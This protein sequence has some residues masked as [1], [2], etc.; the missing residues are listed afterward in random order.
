MLSPRST[1][2][3]TVP[4][5][6]LRVAWTPGPGV[7][8]VWARTT[9]ST[10]V[11]TPSSQCLSTAV[12]SGATG[13]RRSPCMCTSLCSGG[14]STP[15]SGRRSCISA[16]GSGGGAPWTRR[17]TLKVAPFIQGCQLLHGRCLTADRLG[18]LAGFAW[19]AGG[20]GGLGPGGLGGLR[21]GGLWRTV[22][23]RWWTHR[24]HCFGITPFVK[25]CRTSMC[26]GW[27]FHGTQSVLTIWVDRTF[28]YLSI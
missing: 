24:I 20:L 16:W 12:Q 15:A 22:G 10:P 27:K 26:T 19:R 2:T 9:A 28:A 18:G 17:C 3:T 23:R 14:S 5:P 11:R 7:R 8:L 1:L 6:L 25:V 21:L 13:T 4:T